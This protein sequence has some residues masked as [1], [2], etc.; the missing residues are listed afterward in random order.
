MTWRRGR[1]S[2]RVGVLTGGERMM[3][4]KGGEAGVDGGAGGR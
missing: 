3:N 2:E 1:E 4:S